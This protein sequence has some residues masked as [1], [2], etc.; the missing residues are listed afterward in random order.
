[1]WHQMQIKK[2]KQSGFTTWVIEIQRCKTE[3]GD[4][5]I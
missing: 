3:K 4:L 2:E 1:M 5:V